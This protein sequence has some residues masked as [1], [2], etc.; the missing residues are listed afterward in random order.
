MNFVALQMLVGDRAKYF[1][2]VFGVTLA[3][4]L[5]THQA[6]IFVGIMM[7]TASIVTDVT[8]VDVMV[9]D[10]RTEFLDD[11]RPMP[12]DQLLRVRG[13]AGV[14]WAV[15]MFKAPIKAS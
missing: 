5:M 1:G 13:V 8:G 2:I 9:T 7:R 12:D 10:P 3:S 4:L 14:E 15:P 11:V 6:T